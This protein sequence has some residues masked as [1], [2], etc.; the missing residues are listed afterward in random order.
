MCNLL[1]Q[2]SESYEDHPSAEDLFQI[3][4][5]CS[6]SELQMSIAITKTLIHENLITDNVMLALPYNSVISISTG[7]QAWLNVPTAKTQ[8]CPW[9]LSY[10]PIS[11]S[12][13]ILLTLF[14]F[15]AG[16]NEEWELPVRLLQLWVLSA[17]VLKWWFH[18]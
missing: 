17:D 15:S 18:T 10:P 3:I 7:I 1:L 12:Y 9:N 2:I 6:Y 5:I 16:A 4:A 14:R 8:E 13:R 11:S